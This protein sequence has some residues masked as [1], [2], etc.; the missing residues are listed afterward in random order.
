MQLPSEVPLMTL[1]NA[2]LF[3]DA[4]LPLYIF[5][6]RYRKMLF[7]ALHSNRMLS[8]AMQKPG[9]TRETPCQV[10]GLGLIRASVAGRDGTSHLILQGLARVELV[11]AVRYKPYRIQRIRALETTGTQGEGIEALVSKVIGLVARRLE[12]GSALPINVLSKLEELE[13]DRGG[14]GLLGVKQV[15][16]YLMKVENADRL[17]DLV[18]CT[19]LT[20][21]TA[22]QVLLETTDL[23]LRLKHLIRFLTDEIQQSEKK[24]DQ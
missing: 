20:K 7:D 17:A 4:M 15:I 11:G 3:P 2:I 21:S 23:E 8:V 19:L 13:D 14:S 22:R 12:Q 10:A 1:P 18:S 5:E 6:P 24:K 16:D 9:R